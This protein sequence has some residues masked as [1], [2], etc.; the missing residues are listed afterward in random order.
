MPGPDHRRPVR[1]RRHRT[2]RPA[3][4]RRARADLPAA[5]PR[6]RA[7][8]ARRVRLHLRARQGQGAAARQRRR[9][10]LQ[11]PDDHAGPAGRRAARPRT[12]STSRSCTPPPSS[13]STPP[14]CWPRSTPT[15]SRSPWRTTPSSAACSRPSPPPPSAPGSAQRVVPVALP[16]EFLDAGA[17]PTLHDRYGLATDRIVER[18][19]EPALRRASTAAVRSRTRC[20][21]SSST[22]SDQRRTVMTIPHALAGLDQDQPARAGAW[23]RCAPPSPAGSCR[24]RPRWSRPSCPSSC[25]SAAARSARPCAS[26]S[27]KACWSPRP[28]GASPSATSDAKEIRD[29]FAVRAALESLA[30]RT[31]AAAGPTGVTSSTSSRLRSRRWPRRRQR[32]LEERIESDLDFHRTMCRLTGNETLLH[33]WEALEGSIRMSIMFAGDGPSG[34]WTSTGTTTSSTPSSPA[35][36]TEPRPS[37]IT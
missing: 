8:R 37:R 33:T 20:R 12:T 18:V 11:R 4:R 35:T 3:A 32:D 16:D 13:R 15:G 6:Q 31:L 27:R 2:G 10:H 30:A 22:S 1:L 34:T 23:P 25:R 36:P 5:A 17:L 29:I 26:C 21:Q 19:L 28:A 7:H 24:R 9:L 14:P